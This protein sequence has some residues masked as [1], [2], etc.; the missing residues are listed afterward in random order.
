MVRTAP[1]VRRRV[2]PTV[3]A[4]IVKLVIVRAW[5]SVTTYG[6]PLASRNAL[7]MA[8]GSTPPVQRAPS[9]QSPFRGVSQWRSTWARDSAVTEQNI[10]TATIGAPPQRMTGFFI[11]LS[12]PPVSRPRN[13]GSPLNAFPRERLGHEPFP[14][15][16][17]TCLPHR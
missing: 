17:T 16:Y 3:G 7:S 5:S 2:L 13:A 9:V 4:V 12:P 11:G 10:T 8:C 15:H 6:P 14:N 1:L